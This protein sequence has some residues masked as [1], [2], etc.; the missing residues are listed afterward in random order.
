MLPPKLIVR[1]AVPVVVVYALLMI[2]WSGLERGYAGI[3]RAGGDAM[4]SR[5]WFWPS[6][7]VRFLALRSDKLFDDLDAATPGQLPRGVNLPGPE[8]VKDT[9][10][11]LMNSAKPDNFGLLRTGSRYL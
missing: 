7:N 5:F 1:F 11:V 4:F 10:M 3:F 2:P 9:L 8:V 6:G